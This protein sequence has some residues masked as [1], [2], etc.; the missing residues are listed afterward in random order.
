[1]YDAALC[2]SSIPTLT[3]GWMESRKEGAR[4]SH[5]WMRGVADVD[6]GGR[7]LQ[8]RVTHKHRRCSLVRFGLDHEI[9]IDIVFR[10]VHALARDAFG[11][12]DREPLV[13]YHALVFGHPLLPGLHHLVGLRGAGRFVDLGHPLLD[14]GCGDAKEYE[15]F[16][17]RAG[18]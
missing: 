1:M 10:I 18:R 14:S 16:F 15:E 17:H 5:P 8:V 7:D 9:P 12:A 11:L 3:R 13:E 4:E 2:G 6:I